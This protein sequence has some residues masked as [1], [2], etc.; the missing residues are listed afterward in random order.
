MRASTWSA[1][2]RC[3]T[4]WPRGRCPRPRW[5][6]APRSSSRAAAWPGWRRRAAC[7][8]PGCTTLP[9]W[10]WKTPPA[11]TAGPVRSMAWP[12]RWART[13]CPC[14]ATTRPRCKTCWKNWACASAWP[15]A[16][17]TTNAT[18]ATARK[19]A[20]TLSASGRKACCPC[21]AWAK[22]RWS[23]T[24]ASRRP[25]ALPAAL[26]ASPCRS[27]PLWMQKQAWRPPIKR[28]ML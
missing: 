23:N 11:A 1:A 12:A 13:T 25:W 8:W 27:L 19:S 9:C 21:K 18:C 7:A 24:A 15:G 20:C 16:G 28:W 4:C 14:R 5:C 17:S 22:P 10:S 6:G 26:P 3:A 2:T